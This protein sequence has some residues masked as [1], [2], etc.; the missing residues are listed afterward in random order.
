MGVMAQVRQV[1]TNIKKGVSVREVIAELA[2]NQTV[3]A[4]LASAAGDDAPP[5]PLDRVVLVRRSESGA[6]VVVGS[7]DPKYIPKATPGERRLYGRDTLG[8]EASF[9][10]LKGSGVLELNGNADNAVRFAALKAKLDTLEAQLKAHVHPGVTGG[11]SSTGASVTD[12]DTDIA[13]AKVDT[14]KLP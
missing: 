2:L 13:A 4:E 14:V 12:F 9:I 8:V 1:I 5:L 10:W 11:S 3:L 7:I 6:W